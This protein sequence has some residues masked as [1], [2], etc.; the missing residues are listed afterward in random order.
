MRYFKR[1]W[2]EDR[3]HEYASWGG[4]VYYVETGE[5]WYAVRQMEVYDNGPV[6]K[7]GLE[8]FGDDYG[9]LSDTPLN[10]REFGPYEITQDE[11]ETAWNSSKAINQ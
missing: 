1:Y 2:N 7:Y 6:L 9:M 10:D 8:H 5:D 11:F 3:G 4:S